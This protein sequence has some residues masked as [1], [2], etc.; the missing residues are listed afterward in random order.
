M[1]KLS[2][3][4][5][6]LAVKDKTLDLLE[7]GH[8]KKAIYEHFIESEKITMS[9]PSWAKIIDYHEEPK[10][11]AKDIHKRAKKS[12]ETQSSPTPTVRGFGHENKPYLN[13]PGKKEDK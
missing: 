2:C 7:K 13:T 3:K 1:I 10:P 4:S 12:Q 5:Q 9:Y 11:F 6:F 8:S